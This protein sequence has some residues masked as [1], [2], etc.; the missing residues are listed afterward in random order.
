MCPSRL[1]LAPTRGR[2]RELSKNVFRNI[3]HIS[4]TS[5]NGAREG[6]RY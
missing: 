2:W 3:S 5:D 4:N 1:A 6:I